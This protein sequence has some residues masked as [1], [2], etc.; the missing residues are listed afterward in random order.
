[1]PAVRAGFAQNAR[2]TR[3]DKFQYKNMFQFV[4]VAFLFGT[5]IRSMSMDRRFSVRVVALLMLLTAS[6]TFLFSYVVFD[7]RFGLNSEHHADVQRF[8][9]LREVISARYVGEADEAHLTEVALAATVHALGDRWSRYLTAEE[10]VYHLV[11]VQNQHQG[12]GILFNREEDT[13]EVWIDSVTPGSPAE[14]AGLLAGDVI[15]RMAGRDTAELENEEVRQLVTDHFGESIVLEVRGTDDAMRTVYVEVRTF[16]V[17]PVTFEMMEGNVGYIRI[18]NFDITS[19]EKAVAAIDALL[20]EGAVSLICDVRTNPGGRV[21]ELLMVL[22][23]LLPEGELFVFEDQDGTEHVRTSGPDY[24]AMP[25]VVL[26]NENSFSAA[27][28]FA[29]ILQE[30]DW[31]QI[32]GE[33]TSGKGRSQIII[34]LRAGAALQLSTSRYLTPGRVDLYEAGGVT[35]DYVMENEPGEDLQLE[36]ALG[37]L[38]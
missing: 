31:A 25:M 13:N 18:A 36:W 8:R 17:N 6:L 15:V 21:N 32:V 37:L 16:F 9:E 4:L 5:S 12:I 26:V 11:R 7:H 29:A 20:E 34:P 3:L 38:R 28:F 30:E 10:Y 22:D 23:Y 19:R 1:M 35:P 14:E 33:Q 24:L 2:K 27:E